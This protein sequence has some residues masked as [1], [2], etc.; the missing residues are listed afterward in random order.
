M[1]N[2][3]KVYLEMREAME[4][5]GLIT[6]IRVHGHIYQVTYFEFVQDII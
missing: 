5:F 6:V 4:M 2:E 1:E 3:L